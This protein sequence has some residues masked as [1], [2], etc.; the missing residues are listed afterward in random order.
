MWGVQLQAKILCDFLAQIIGDHK[1]F[2]WQASWGKAALFHRTVHIIYTAVKDPWQVLLFCIF[3]FLVQIHSFIPFIWGLGQRS[4]RSLCWG[5]LLCGEGGGK[6]LRTTFPTLTH[7]S[8]VA[9][10]SLY[11]LP[12]PQPQGP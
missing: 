1:G 4:S 2:T 9:I 3:E 6:T 5:L 10:P 7:Y 11:S 8:I 12:S